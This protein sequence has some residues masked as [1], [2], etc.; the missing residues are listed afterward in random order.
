MYQQ[1]GNAI[2]AAVAAAWV[3]GVAE[4]YNSGIGGGGFMLVYDAKQ[5]QVSALDYREAAPQLANENSFQDKSST[6]GY[7]AS[8][9]PGLVRGLERAHQ[10]YG[11]LPWAATFQP[12]I[13]LAREGF[14][15]SA[16]LE[17]RL[18]D[19]AN[20]LGRFGGSRRV[21]FRK[22]QPLKRGTFFKQEDLA[23]SLEMIAKEGSAAFY[24]GSIA[25]KIVTA[26]T[27]HDGL[28]RAADL[29]NYQARQAN[30]IQFTYHDYTI[31]SMPL[32]SSG[33]LLMQEMFAVS[34]AQPV[35]KW[36]W[37]SPQEAFHLSRTMKQAFAKRL[38]LGESTPNKAQ[39]THASFAD[40]HGNVVAMTNSLNLAFGSCVVIPHTG[41]LMNDHMDDFT[42]DQEKPNAFGL[43]QGRT[44]RVAAG[45]RPLSSMSPTLIFEKSR[46]LYVLGSPG[47]PTIISNIFQL[48]INLLDH[49]MNLHDA[50]AA[51]KL[52]HQHNP[53][54]VYHQRAYPTATL[55][56]LRKNGHQLRYRPE[57]GNINAVHIDQKT[58]H[59]QGAS[60]PR[61]EGQV[62][63]LRP[64]DATAVS[65]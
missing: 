31:Y 33:G 27:Q 21:F 61:G 36:G 38:E 62:G 16:S 13:Q 4:P 1:G 18:I 57:W 5:A 26:M 37:A 22:S 3:L 59:A 44:N 48:S 63:A 35:Q 19:R 52:H 20:C 7:A 42:T 12:A 29:K 25:K 64:L 47:G 58:G 49:G 43:M 60:D 51:P 10:A 54:L 9:V 15:V 30:P 41:I 40:H 46:P 32:P 39:T 23:A 17:K 14:P 55:S 65:R 6:M 45:R 53:D 8:G 50:I 56:A 34:E 11:A 24:D 2:D 28:I